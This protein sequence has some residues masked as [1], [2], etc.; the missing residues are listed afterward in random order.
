MSHK[1]YFGMFKNITDV[2]QA[3]HLADCMILPTDD[4]LFAAYLEGSY[5]GWARVLFVRGGQLYEVDASHCSCYGLEGQWDPQ[6]V[7]WDQLAMRPPFN[8]DGCYDIYDD[9][10]NDS[11]AAT[12]E[13]NR[14]IRSHVPRA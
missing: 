8:D 7:S 3:F 5:S 2:Q 11:T 1:K 6:E 14:L 9:D 4:V 12:N 10:P 13:W